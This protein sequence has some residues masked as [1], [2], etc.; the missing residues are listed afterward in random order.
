MQE[1][2]SSPVGVCSCENGESLSHVAALDSLSKA[3]REALLLVSFTGRL[4]LLSLFVQVV[5]SHVALR[6]LVL[7]AAM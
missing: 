1:E 5:V 2:R 4:P 6:R 7:S 3:K